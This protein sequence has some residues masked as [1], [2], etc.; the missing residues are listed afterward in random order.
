M[1]LLEERNIP[2]TVKWAE[3]S[4]DTKPEG[5]FWSTPWSYGQWKRHH[6]VQLYDCTY[7]TN[8]KGL[9]LFQVVGLNHMGMAFSCAFGLINNE[10]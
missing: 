4:D 9:A 3:G 5:L 10:K 7:K 1:K 2:Y 6:Y 8:N